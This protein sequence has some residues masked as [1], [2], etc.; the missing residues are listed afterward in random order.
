ARGDR[1]GLGAL[2]PAA[3]AERVEEHQLVVHTRPHTEVSG[4]SDAQDFQADAAADL[5]DEHRERDRDAELPVEDVVEAAVARIVVVVGVTAEA[6]LVEQEL[7]Q[8]LEGMRAS[9]RAWVVASRSRSVRP[10][11]W[12]YRSSGSIT[13]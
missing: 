8:P 9:C 1:L 5:H 6:L 12:W 13:S 11:S 4:Q 7:A 10:S 2:E 3:A